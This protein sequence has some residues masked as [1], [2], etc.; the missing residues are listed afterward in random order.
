[1]IGLIFLCAGLCHFNRRNR[2][3][4]E[5]AAQ[6]LQDKYLEINTNDSD[7]LTGYESPN[8]AIKHVKVNL[9][10]NILN[11]ARKKFVKDA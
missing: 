10:K 1:M 6:E 3:D 9:W 2:Y 7:S 8:S 4:E 5:V 11:S